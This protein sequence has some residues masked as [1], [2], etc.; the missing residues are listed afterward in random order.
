MKSVLMSHPH[1][2]ANVRETALALAEGDVLREFWTGIAWNPDSLVGRHLPE[3]ASRQ[4]NRRAFPKP[5]RPLIRAHPWRE[6]ARLTSRSL[7]LGGLAESSFLSPNACHEALDRKVAGVLRK[8]ARDFD[9]VYA[10]DH[11]ALDTF[12]AA[13]RCGLRKIYDLPIGYWR[14]LKALMSEEIANWPEWHGS[15]TWNFDPKTYDRKDAEIA[16]ADRIIVASSFTQ[17]TLLDHGVPRGQIVVV[18]YGSPP[19]AFVPDSDLDRSTG[20]LRVLYVGSLDLRKG[21]PY[22]FGAVAQL[23]GRLDV[24]VIGRGAAMPAPLVDALRR[25][26]WIESLPHDETIAWMRRCDVLVLPTLFEGFGLVVTEAMSQGCAVITTPNTCGTD[27]I[28]DGSDGFIVPIRSTDAIV[29][30]LDRLDRDRDTLRRVRSAALERM[31][32]QTWKDF[33]QRVRLASQC[34][35]VPSTA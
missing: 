15:S 7:H 22:F 12:K 34:T 31:R 27:V 35:P 20:P 21:M 19:P 3:A 6:L 10:Y 13:T 2:N 11:C 30:A 5:V 23:E 26:R 1:G 33:R 18:P 16:L 17:Q 24:T 28:T 14:A 32:K 29:A 9:T 8:R 4:L 25:C